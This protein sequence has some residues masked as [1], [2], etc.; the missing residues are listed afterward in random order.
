MG[1]KSFVYCPIING[2]YDTDT[3]YDRIEDIDNYMVDYAVLDAL[4]LEYYFTISIH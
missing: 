1:R 2:Y 3:Q 4:S